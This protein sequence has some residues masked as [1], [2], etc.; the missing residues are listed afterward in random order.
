MHWQQTGGGPGRGTVTCQSNDLGLVASLTWSCPPCVTVFLVKVIFLKPCRGTSRCTSSQARGPSLAAEE[1]AQGTCQSY[2][3]GLAASLTL[4]LSFRD[5]C[6]GAAAVRRCPLRAT[7]CLRLGPTASRAR[8]RTP[9][10]FQMLDIRSR[11]LFL[12]CSCNDV[13]YE[14]SI[15]FRTYMDFSLEVYQN[16][17]LVLTT[18]SGR[19]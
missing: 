15:L 4:E 18:T 2:D 11:G 8:Q 16:R 3:L 6:S 17:R 14:V 13:C 7:D 10:Q 12:L 5:Y 9:Q 19:S 1:A